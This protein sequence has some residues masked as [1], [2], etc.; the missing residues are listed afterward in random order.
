MDRPEPT[1][2]SSPSNGTVA[3]LAPLT[4]DDQAKEAF[5][6]PNMK[7]NTKSSKHPQHE[8]SLVSST[9]APSDPEDRPRPPSPD[10]P[11]ETALPTAA[12]GGSVPSMSG[13]LFKGSS[14]SNGC[15]AKGGSKPSDQVTQ[16]YSAAPSSAPESQ[17]TTGSSWQQ[18]HLLSLS[19]IATSLSS[20]A[21][22]EVA[23]SHTGTADPVDHQAEGSAK[24]SGQASQPKVAAPV[25]TASLADT[26][27]PSDHQTE[28]SSKESD[29]APQSKVVASVVAA[30]QTHHSGHQAEG[31]SKEY[32][33]A[34]QS[35]R[36]TGFPWLEEP[37]PAPFHP[38]KAANGTGPAE[39]P[40]SIIG[41]SDDNAGGIFD[42]ADD[43]DQMQLPGLASNS[44]EPERVRISSLLLASPSVPERIS[45]VRRL[46]IRSIVTGTPTKLPAMNAASSAEGVKA[47]GQIAVKQEATE[48]VK[49]RKKRGTK[50]P[51]MKRPLQGRILLSKKESEQASALFRGKGDL[52][53]CLSQKDCLFLA[54]RFWIFTVEQLEFVLNTESKES[55]SSSSK[56]LDEILSELARRSLPQQQEDPGAELDGEALVIND[57]TQA[58]EPGLQESMDVTIDELR[59]TGND[60]DASAA[61]SVVCGPSSQESSITLASASDLVTNQSNV[62][63]PFGDSTHKMEVDTTISET[64]TNEPSSSQR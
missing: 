49:S 34:S 3:K 8:S 23:A 42:D 25:V 29:H 12:K 11:L 1:S 22:P 54:D 52:S 6:L 44:V 7:S 35:Q 14:S 64:N 2:Y 27:H 56:L 13:P 15:D 28:G 21:A 5:Q 32:G 31:S 4:T 10:K 58:P 46:A 9:D 62:A 36:P 50:E 55:E 30:S 47:G 17:N 20:I 61:E 48:Q 45:D 43:D 24:E 26:T 37:S 18:Q 51:K 59:S 41:S 38:P 39:P 60:L 40:A 63:P 16:S 57:A 19:N 33:Q 53:E